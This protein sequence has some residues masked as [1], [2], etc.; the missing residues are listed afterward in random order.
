MLSSILHWAATAM[1]NWKLLALPG[2]VARTWHMAAPDITDEA[3][4][5]D[6]EAK[7]VKN[8]MEVQAS[9]GGHQKA[10]KGEEL[11]DPKSCRQQVCKSNSFIDF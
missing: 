1:S 6:Q 9:T 5:D 8:K 3:E 11:E 4:D 7:T 2:G 10:S